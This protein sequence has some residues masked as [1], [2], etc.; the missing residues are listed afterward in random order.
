MQNGNRYLYLL[1]FGSVINNQSTSQI[2][3]YEVSS[4]GINL[5]STIL[6]D[7][8]FN[9][10]Q[11]LE[12][13]LSEDRTKLAFANSNGNKAYVIHLNPLTGDLNP[14]AGNQGNG[15]SEFTIPS[16]SNMLTGVEFSPSGENLFIGSKD[17]GI[18]FVEINS[19]TVSNNPI[20]GSDDYGNSY[21]ELA[22]E[23]TGIQRIY[24]VSDDPSGTQSM[25]VLTGI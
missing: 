17:D 3:K 9:N 15:V 1:G 25:G 13:E 2:L 18:F 19:S 6:T 5:V 11:S 12:L 23:P 20:V 10:V 7:T 22:Y 4:S 24:A 16:S 14:T 21:L 8:Q